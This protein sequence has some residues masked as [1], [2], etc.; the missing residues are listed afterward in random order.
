MPITPHMISLPVGTQGQ[1]I[2][3]IS[4]DWSRD[5]EYTA[6]FTSQGASNGIAVVQSVFINNEKC[7]ADISI[8]ISGT[9]TNYTVMAGQVG[10]FP[11]YANGLPKITMQAEQGTGQTFFALPILRSLY[12]LITRNRLHRPFLMKHCVKQPTQTRRTVTPL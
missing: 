3:P 7:T 4:C 2:F 5:T 8:S 12:L 10:V 1:R 6:D 9:A 11:I